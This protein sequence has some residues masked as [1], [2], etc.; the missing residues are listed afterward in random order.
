VTEAASEVSV[1][2]S[3]KF[4]A[5]VRRLSRSR[6]AI[7][8]VAV[9]VT[10]AVA[11]GVAWGLQSPVDGT[12]VVHGCYNA[13]TGAFRLQVGAACPSKGAKTPISWNQQG[14][15]GPPQTIS[16]ASGNTQMTTTSTAWAD[17]PGATKDFTVTDPQALVVI[18]MSAVT[19]CAST[20]VPTDTDT[21]MMRVLV[22]GQPTQPD[23]GPDGGYMIA[24]VSPYNNSGGASSMR[25]Y[26]VVPQGSHTVD[27]QW[28]AQDVAPL[29]SGTTWYLNFWTLT[30]EQFSQFSN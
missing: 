22:D 18:E 26:A 7:T 8:C 17:I 21:C 4:G 13:Q 24:R 29:N 5:R 30:V 23:L 11:G 20:I 15:T 16:V 28:L 25:A 3:A 12:G 19:G 2:G 6:L 9:V 10:G 1:D 14:A 27:V